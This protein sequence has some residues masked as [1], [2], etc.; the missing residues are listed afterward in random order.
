MSYTI[1]DI[2]DIVKGELF[3]KNA[4]GNIKHLLLDSRKVVNP[5]TSLFFALQGP[6]RNGHQFIS[7]LYDKGVCNFIVQSKISVEGIPFIN[8]VVVQDTL[9]ALQVL[10]EYHRKQY[11]I[12]VIG[13]TGSNGKT[14]VKEWLNQLLEDEYEVVRSPKSYNSQTG[15]P[16][17]VWQINGLH[18]LGIF[19]A[20]ISE[21]DEMDKLE[22]IVQPTIGILT[23]IGEAHSG[24]FENIRQKVDEK[25][26]LFK[27]VTTLIH[28]KDHPS[29]NEGIASYLNPLRISSNALP[30]NFFSWSCTSDATLRITSIVK[31]PTGTVI[32]AICHERTIGIRI[33]FTDEASVENSITCWAVLLF[34]NVDE[35]NTGRI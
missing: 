33:P 24:G 7:E 4:P 8:A 10:A 28:C 19:E 35:K 22:K 12:P 14:I 11:N 32:S 5:S 26:R 6:R 3:I 21:T 31:D 13:I 29:V 34:L 20:G 17:S 23:N 15:V 16:L 1:D 30:I 9:N 27:N 2:A 18:R 25:L